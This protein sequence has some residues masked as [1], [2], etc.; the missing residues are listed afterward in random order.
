M[1]QT[2]E[3]K[4]VVEGGRRSVQHA[5]MSKCHF[6]DKRAMARACAAP[7]SLKILRRTFNDLPAAIQQLALGRCHMNAGVC[8][9][10]ANYANNL[11][12]VYRA[13]QHKKETG[14]RLD[15]GH[16]IFN[17]RAL[18]D[19]IVDAAGGHTQLPHVIR[20]AHGATTGNFGNIGIAD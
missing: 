17:A 15:E 9:Q 14:N 7:N 6:C 8:S 2:T 4:S 11:N 12:A 16:T 20:C 10:K 18:A 3:R 13:G 1:G 5:N 19:A